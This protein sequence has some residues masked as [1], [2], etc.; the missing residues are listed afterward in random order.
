MTIQVAIQERFA[1]ML[2]PL[3]HLGQTVDVALR[4]FATQQIPTKIMELR[5]RRSRSSQ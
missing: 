4:R 2:A 3:G 5:R 1:Q